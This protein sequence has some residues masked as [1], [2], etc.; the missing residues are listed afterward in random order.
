VLR[1]NTLKSNLSLNLFSFVGLVLPYGSPDC[2]AMYK[3]GDQ[4]K[5]PQLCSPIILIKNLL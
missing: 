3:E 1:E 5:I 4:T 2:P